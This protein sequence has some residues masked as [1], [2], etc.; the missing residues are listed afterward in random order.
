MTQMIAVTGATGCVG[1]ELVT[2]LL[3]QGTSVLAF[4]SDEAQLRTYLTNHGI[5]ADDDALIVVS[6]NDFDALKAHPVELLINCAFP[7]SDEGKALAAGMHYAQSLFE[8][9]RDARV[10]GVINI[11][12]QSVYSQTRE[13][14]ATES[15]PICPD[16]KYAVAKY[17]VE[18]IADLILADLPHT[19]IRL[20]SLFG[21]T[22]GQRFVNFFV[23]QMVANKPIKVRGFEQEYGFLDYRDAALGLAAMV[24]SDPTA[25]KPVY[26]L[27]PHTGGYTMD[28]ILHTTVD[29]AK[30]R[31]LKP[32]FSVE[33]D[34]PWFN[35][36][37][38]SELFEQDFDWSSCY[39]LKDTIEDIFSVAD[40][41]GSPTP[42]LS[43][44]EESARR[45]PKKRFGIF[46]K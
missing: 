22:F 19:N 28:R 25:W 18:M 13:H 6:R 42:T 4:S 36:S 32:S 14:E 2:Q 12:S 21:S 24:G 29:V 23:K 45:K 33:Y 20:A 26:N 41:T 44:Q 7:R 34:C 46:G 27:G 16:G 8:A 15:E 1:K 43:N 31:G 10:G 39:T 40:P 11:S 5:T 30:S 9:A 3:A 17:A 38:N 37:L 35:S